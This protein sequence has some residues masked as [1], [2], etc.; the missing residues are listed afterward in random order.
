MIPVNYAWAVGAACMVL[1]LG[2][3]YV[4]RLLTGDGLCACIH[5][6]LRRVSGGKT[7]RDTTYCHQVV[8]LLLQADAMYSDVVK[9]GQVAHT[10]VRSDWEA[11]LRAYRNKWGAVC[12]AVEGAH[13]A[14]TEAGVSREPQGTLRQRGG[15]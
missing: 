9:L 14:A 15:G 10:N 13:A 3:L 12:R 4:G 8:P 1:C 5:G 11:A 2:A 6:E 7:Q